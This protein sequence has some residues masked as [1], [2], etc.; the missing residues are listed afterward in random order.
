MFFQAR[1]TIQ[2]RY[3]D[4]QRTNRSRGVVNACDNKLLT[5]SHFSS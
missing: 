4:E 3:G 2:V 1:A 5:E